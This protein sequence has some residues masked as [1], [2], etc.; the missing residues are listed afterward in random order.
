MYTTKFISSGLYDNVSLGVLSAMYWKW[1]CWN[2][3]VHDCSG[4]ICNAPLNKK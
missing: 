1:Q 3:I 2:Y 4:E